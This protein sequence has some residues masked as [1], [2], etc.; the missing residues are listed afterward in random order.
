MTK[1]IV[2]MLL[3]FSGA[4]I[5]G[6]I[7]A[8]PN[9][10]AAPLRVSQGAL[11]KF[12]T[13]PRVYLAKDDNG[14]L[15]WIR[16][17]A[18]LLRRGLKM[19]Q[20]SSVSDSHIE[21]YKVLPSEIVEVAK[22]VVSLEDQQPVSDETIVMVIDNGQVIM[23]QGGQSLWSAA[24]ITKLMS[25]LVLHDMNLNW[26]TSVTMAKGDEVGGARLRVAVGSR[27]RR[28][29]LL[30]ATLMGS[31][32][33]STYTLARTSGI[34][35]PQFVARMNAKARELGM[36]NSH[37]VDPTGLEPM[38]ISTAADIAILIKAANEVPRIAE[39]GKK[40]SY[41]LLST[42]KKPKEHTIKT[43][44]AL[45]RAGDPVSLG[46]TGYLE[47]SRYNFTV[48]A[49]GPNGQDRTV[50]VLNAPSQASVYSLAKKYVYQN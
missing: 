45:L 17:E 47:E 22:P 37:F 43:T 23:D 4:I 39:I 50:V 9:V 16:T 29:D 5:L 2:R 44:N 8:A 7:L 21:L 48:L 28:V 18:E 14:T 24:S 13:D 15:E 30:H 46:K 31:A 27:Y 11:V 25:A 49:L 35:V 10:H 32:N 6:M 42:D 26:N 3:T 19:S 38:N 33:N 20:I 40:T 12:Q 34:T 36:V 1:P 41:T